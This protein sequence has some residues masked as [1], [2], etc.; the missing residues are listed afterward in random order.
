MLLSLICAIAVPARAQ[1]SNADFQQAVAVYQQSLTTEAAEKVIRMA[2]A[3]EQLPPI[4]EEARR[5]FVRGTTLFKD[6]KSPDDYKQVVDE[7][8][9]AANIAPWWP[10]ARY[11]RALAWEAA[12]NYEKAIINLK[13]YLLFKL[14]VTE[15]RAVQDKIYALEA[16]QEKAELGQELLN[17]ISRA[18]SPGALALI[19]KGADVNV[20]Y[21][22]AAGGGSALYQAV[23]NGQTDVV[24]AMIDKGADVNAQ[25]PKT[26]WTPLMIAVFFNRFDIA[27]MLIG[28]GANVNSADINGETILMITADSRCDA[29]FMQLL[30]DRGASASVN[31][32]NSHGKSALRRAIEFNRQD[33]AQMLR[34]AGAK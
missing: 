8:G 18:D 2:V 30:I 33:L 29:G 34:D 3:M 24:R 27:R 15:A 10:D 28:S 21:P 13:L 11:N 6:A 4:P 12:G 20:Q 5:H 26:G 32:I 31:A 9:Q 7:F 16:R 23:C 25:V 22:E 19:A 14:P 17:A 1:A